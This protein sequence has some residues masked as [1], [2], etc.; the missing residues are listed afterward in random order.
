M[1]KLSIITVCFNAAE[2]L[3][4]TIESVLNQVKVED[5]AIEHLIIDNMSSDNTS[6]IVSYYKSRLDNTA[7]NIINVKYIC[8]PDR[9]I[10]DAM[11][12]GIN[13]ANGEW[14]ILLNAGDTFYNGYVLKK[15]IV[16]LNKKCDVIVGKYN[17]LDPSGNAIITPPPIEKIRDRM[18]FCHQAIV[19]RVS[20]HK[21][22]RYNLNYKIVADYDAVLRMY[23]DNRKFYYVDE[24]FVNYD[25][26]GLSA[27][28]MIETH[29][30]MHRV[31]QDHEV[32]DEKLKDSAI[33]AYGLIK[34]VLLLKMPQGLRWK[35]V[36]FRNRHLE[37]KYL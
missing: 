9:G 8:E 28:K 18:I 26:T 5:L 23:L 4:K 25:A 29:K 36:G 3:N 7:K 1:T 37:K 10:Y 27:N 15:I 21:C 13:L 20:I 35:I 22:Y 17:R 33:F 31:R 11:N 2:E 30:E 12:K 6:E 34:R 14:M 16:N 24:C 19:F 32:I